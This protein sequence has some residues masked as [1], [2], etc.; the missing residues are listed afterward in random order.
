VLK[1][2]IESSQGDLLTTWRS[3]EQ[4]V[5]N[6]IR[7]LQCNRAKDQI[8]TPLDLDRPQ[9]H[10]CLGYITTPAL[11]LV[12]DH[13]IHA[14]K[15][16]GPC[17]GVYTATWGL[18]CAH[19]LERAKELGISLLVEQFHKHW[20]WDRDSAPFEPTL[21]PLRVVTYNQREANEP[22][23][24]RQR[25]RQAKRSTRRLPSNF[26]A[27]EPRERRCGLCRLP[28]H[29]RTSMRCTVNMR[30]IQ[31]ELGVD[32]IILSPPLAMV[33]DSLN[34]GD[35]HT[36][37][38]P[39]TIAQGALQQ[40][41][42][43]PSA[44]GTENP[45]TPQPTPQD[46]RPIW[47]GRPELIYQ[48]YLAEKEAWLASNPLVLPAQYRTNRGLTKWS[49]KW[50]QQNKKFLPASRL[51]LETETLIRGDPKWTI[52]EMYAWLDWDQRKD[53]EAEQEAEAE[54]ITAGGFGQLRDGAGLQ[55]GMRRVTANIMAEER[56]YRFTRS[57]VL[58]DWELSSDSGDI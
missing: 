45:E 57:E 12:Q 21:E 58:Y 9:Y 30:R 28:G 24:Q 13:Y 26:E 18:P 4:A 7:A 29:T 42:S 5:T 15:P 32:R 35:L 41:K 14:K 37:S 27:T 2:Y 31:Q 22:L 10:A 52:E 55:A 53:Q 34:S 20:Y 50:C 25:Q 43:G 56:Q 23:A 19:Q 39:Q 46:T 51:N 54:L 3:I 38:Q 8:R 48:A 33:P 36:N 49:N 17:T 6:Q 40:L 44:Q 47:P 11:R 1:R 16:L